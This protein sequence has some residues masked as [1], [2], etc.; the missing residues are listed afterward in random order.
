MTSNQG[1]HNSHGIIRLEIRREQVFCYLPHQVTSE[2]VE[3]SFAL[4]SSLLR[5]DLS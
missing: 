1:A 2:L 5:L 4:R 3:N